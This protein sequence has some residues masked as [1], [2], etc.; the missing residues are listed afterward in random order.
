MKK[1]P[2]CGSRKIAPILYGMP[3]Y[4]E[5][6]EQKINHQELYLGG[7]CVTENNP[8]FH[9]FDCGKDVGSAP[10]LISKRGEE[11][12]RKIV[13]SIRFSDGGFFG[14]YNE[15]LIKKCRTGIIADARPDFRNADAPV[16]RTISENEWM[17]LL[18]KLY[19][20][21][22]L[23]EWKKQF[24]DW[25]ILDGEQWELEIRMTNNRVRNYSG[26]NAF[27]PYW[28]E[29]LRIIRPFFKNDI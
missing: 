15:L 7:C 12:Y 11:D 17:K 14:G 6:M 3:V 1:C 25:S 22:F 29:L 10:I 28:N 8:Q 21:L 24:N 23:H 2:K 5:E 13:T 4:D 9:C 18:D 27:P 20:K 16:R 26:S 19:C